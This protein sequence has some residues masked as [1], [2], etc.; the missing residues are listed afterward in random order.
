MLPDPPVFTAL[1]LYG[2][3]VNTGKEYGNRIILSK[4]A[5]YTTETEL[6]YNQNFLTFEFSALNYINHERTYYRYQLEGID[7]Q[8]MSTFAGR[9][10]NATVGKGLLQA[11][12][13][14]YHREIIHSK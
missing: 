9:Q 14:I 12:T 7:P 6:D 5:P 8:W 11:V 4:A 13:P 2:E 1:R 10:G 3:K